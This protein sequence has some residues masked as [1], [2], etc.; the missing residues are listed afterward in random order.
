MC[1]AVIATG[2]HPGLPLI[3][4]HNR[5]EYHSR[6]STPMQWHDQQTYLWGSDIQSKG[7]WLGLNHSGHFAF[8]T[9]YRDPSLNNSTKKS[10]GDIIPAILK[11]DL[12]SPHIIRNMLKDFSR[13]TNPFN[14]IFGQP[15][16]IYYFNSLGQNLIKLPSGIYGLSNSRLNTPWPKV[17]NSKNKIRSLCQSNQI[18]HATLQQSFQDTQVAPD[19]MLPDTGVPIKL[20]ALLSSV[21]V[22]S[23]VY[24]TRS[25]SSV[26]WSDTGDISCQETSWRPDGSMAG[27][28]KFNIYSQ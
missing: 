8:I 6:Q 3:I 22:L 17:L 27:C 20:E 21:F 15:D 18:S 7:T 9:N 10:R 2:H 5:D 11:S 26:I 24:G 12:T 28:N 1:L 25:T 23:P 16:A 4:V 19:S 13:Q 14:V